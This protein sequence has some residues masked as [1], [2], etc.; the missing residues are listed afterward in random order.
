[1]KKSFSL[2][3]VMLSVALVSFVV[4]TVTKVQDNS[5]FFLNKFENS[6]KYNE[7]IT[8]VPNKK[9]SLKQLENT[10]ILLSDYLNFKDD[11]IRK[12]LKEIK[13]LKKEE[14]FDEISIDNEKFKLKVKIIKTN[15]KIDNEIEKNFYTFQLEI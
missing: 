11:D 4:V 7:F 6:S 3:E 1:M 12:K 14:E 8:L 10:N 15:Y 9:S 13:V 2:V 5:H